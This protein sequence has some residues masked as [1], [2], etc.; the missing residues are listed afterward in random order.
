MDPG[1]AEKHLTLTWQHLKVL[2]EPAG[3]SLVDTIWSS[4]NPLEYIRALRTNKESRVLINDFTGQVKPGEMMLVV[5]RPGS[6]C[7]T[8]LKALANQRKPFT[9]VEGDVT[10]GTL[11]WKEALHYRQQIIFNSEEDEHFPTLTV[12]QVMNFSLK[13]KTPKTRPGTMTK[14]EFA[15]GYKSSILRALGI[16]HTHDTLV[17]NEYVRG[18]SG[19]ERKRV[20]I[21]ECLAGQG[22]IQFWD[23]STRGLDASTALDFTKALRSLARRE[24]KTILATFY[25]PGNGIFDQFDKV[26]LIDRGLCLYYGPRAL[27]KAYFEELGF[28]C[29]PG[30]NVADFLS[31]VTVPSERRVR[32]GWAGPVPDSAEEL[33]AIY[34]QSSVRRQMLEAIEPPH[35]LTVQTEKFKA[36]VQN[37][38]R[39]GILRRSLSPYTVGLHEQV[40]A[41]TIRQL[42][43]LWGDKL[44]L[45]LRVLQILLQGLINGSVYYVLTRSSNTAFPRNGALFYPILFFC[46]EATAQM[47]YSFMGRNILTRHKTFAFYKPTAYTIAC[48][49]ADIPLQICQVSFLTL[50]FYF[51]VGFQMDGSKWW[52]FWLNMTVSVLCFMSLYR[53]IGACCRNFGNASKIAAFVTAVMMIYGGYLVP[54]NKMHPWFKWIFYLNPA[55]YTWESLMV[56]EYGGLNIICEE[57]QRV[58]YGPKYDDVRYQAC[59]L[60]GASNA[61]HVNGLDYIYQEYHYSEGHLWRGFGVVVGF[62]FFFIFITALGFEK[63]QSTGNTSSALIFKRG[64]KSTVMHQASLQDEEKQQPA[65]V[66][67]DPLSRSAP[68]PDG[69]VDAAAFTW[70][71]IDYTVPFQ[72]EQKKLLDGV[73]GYV[74]PGQLVAL[75]G[76]SG[77]G[78][79]TLLDVL[80]QR[81]DSGTITG[82]VTVNGREP[83]GDF[84][85]TTG[86]CEQL[87]IHEPSATVREALEFSALLRQADTIPD[88]E[89]LKFVDE[90]ITLLELDDIQDAIVGSPGKGLTIEQRKRLTIGVELVAR[91]TILFLDEPTSGLD[92]QSAFTIVRFMRKLADNGQAIICTI[93]QPSATLFDNFD[94]ILLLARG[95]RTTYYGP[96]GPGS[97]V[98]LDY[99]GRLGAPCP[100]DTNPAEHIVDVVQG[101]VLPGVD[102]YEQWMAAPESEAVMAELEATKSHYSGVSMPTETLEFASPMWKQLKI[103]TKRHCIALWRKPDYIWNKIILHIAQALFNGFS[104]WKAGQSHGILELELRLFSIFIFLFVAGGVIVQLQ[105]LFLANRAIFE[106]REKKSK[107]YSW[108]AFV[109][110]QMIAE[111]PYL[112]LCGTLYFVGFYF[113]VG[114]PTRASI[115]GQFFLEMIFYQFLYTAVGQGIAVFSPNEYFASLVNP[116]ILGAIFIDFCGVLVPYDTLNVFWRYWLYYLDPFTY[117]VQ[118]LFTQT[119][120]NIKVECRPSEMTIITPPPNL[121]CGAY[122]ADFIASHSGYLNNPEAQVDCE[123]CQYT[124]GADYARTFNINANYYGWRGTG[125]TALFVIST[126]AFVYLIMKIRTKATKRAGD[127]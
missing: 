108:I 28:E 27:A 93:H 1:Y 52:I 30:G 71:N 95:G 94:Y 99:F 11:D 110:G 51:M 42:Q 85:R 115:S 116:L 80:A 74:R 109:T 112:I 76:S 64:S 107:T 78:K 121:T 21:A 25:Q 13:N 43:I 114:L 68:A 60:P 7:T 67:S 15:N 16:D 53:A 127:S 70:K 38:R 20:S 48:V 58:P 56:N 8:F 3:D 26:L 22:P 19:G 45:I 81:K 82:E 5:G 119:V 66:N 75:M 101:R 113:T 117:I 50:I 2:G 14:K 72:G 102:W 54:F 36:T 77:A 90:V 49:L 106:A 61:T 88:G 4:A 10:Y 31:S 24:G 62:W 100:K 29:P 120:W 37:E 91:P 122:M 12:G 73:S 83:S 111:I 84:Q 34:L 32:Q 123:Y 103:V 41:C 57:P 40:V 23:N 79:T 47:T 105:P 59:T 17:G 65:R 118:A 6:G 35:E 87:D 86:Y 18:V 33:E 104:F 89:K 69:K 96:T 63:L 44:S 125:I 39:G 124:T 9:G 97:Q 98:I 55:A 92:G 46:L 126:Y